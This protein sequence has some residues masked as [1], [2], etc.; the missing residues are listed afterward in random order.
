MG[1][2]TSKA[3]G[4]NQTP[5][6][7]EK[8]SM[9]E[10]KLIKESWDSIKSHQDFS[11]AIM[12]RIFQEHSVI[13]DRWIFATNLVTEEEMLNNSQVKYHAKKIGDVLARI[14]NIAASSQGVDFDKDK[15]DQ[16]DLIK[17]GRSH[18]H[19]GVARENF[20]VSFPRYFKHCMKFKIY[21]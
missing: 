11:I 16:I 17:L 5:V 8:I 3:D 6:D 7:V 9:K 2:N 18:F 4:G 14:V 1:A 21:V 15:L 13:K 20:S 19:Y 12:V 10:V